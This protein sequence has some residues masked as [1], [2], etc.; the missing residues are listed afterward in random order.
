MASAPKG[1]KNVLISELLSKDITILN[2]METLNIAEL[3]DR[4]SL[5]RLSKDYESKL[6]NKIKNNFTDN[7]QQLFVASFYCFLNYQ[8]R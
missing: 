5:T 2:K 6:L 3:I 1:A 8:L 4:N 7:Q